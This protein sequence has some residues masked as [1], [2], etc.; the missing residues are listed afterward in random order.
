MNNE[1]TNEGAGPM[2]CTARAPRYRDI[3]YS[4]AFVSVLPKEQQELPALV[5]SADLVTEETGVIDATSQQPRPRS[6]ATIPGRT[7]CLSSSARRFRAR[8]GR[9]HLH[10]TNPLPLLVRVPP[11]T[12]AEESP[13]KRA[14]APYRDLP[15][16]KDGYYRAC[17]ASR[18]TLD[19]YKLSPDDKANPK[20]T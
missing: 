6:A 13:P 19:L 15:F 14:L 10:A 8:A 2:P 11:G 7:F 3:R 1:A 9:M 4:L 17:S 16:L 18:M 12:F 20:N 5:S